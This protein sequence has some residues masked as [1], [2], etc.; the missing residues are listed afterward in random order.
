MIKV[1]NVWYPKSQEKL[2]NQI[3]RIRRKA[4]ITEMRKMRQNGTRKC[5]YSSNSR[6]KGSH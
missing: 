4:V 6:R 2:A 5:Y 3:F 1:G